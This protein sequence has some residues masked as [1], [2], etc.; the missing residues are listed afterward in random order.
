MMIFIGLILLISFIVAFVN[1]GYFKS[2]HKEVEFLKSEEMKDL[3]DEEQIKYSYK[4]FFKVIWMFI[5]T[6]TLALMYMC[7]LIG[8]LSVDVLLAPTLFMIT[9]FVGKYVLVFTSRSYKESFKNKDMNKID[10][11]DQLRRGVNIAYILYILILI[12]A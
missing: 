8:A 5:W 10:A 7:F 2:I 11:N 12:I 9:L 3:E 4:T 6:V 1:G